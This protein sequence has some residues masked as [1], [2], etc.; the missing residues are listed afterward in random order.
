MPI[1]CRENDLLW[2]EM[3]HLRGAHIKQQQIVSKLVQYLTVSA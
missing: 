3:G 1:I 2:Q